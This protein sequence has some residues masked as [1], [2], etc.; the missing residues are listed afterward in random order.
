MVMNELIAVVDDEEDISEVIAINLKK[1]GYTPRTFSDG[2]AF[3][4]L[5]K[6]HSPALV[7]LDLMLPDMDGL[8]ICRQLKR[9]AAHAA[10]PVIMLTARGEE[11]DKL[12]G[13]ELGADDYMTKPFSPRELVARVKVVLRRN[14]IQDM[15]SAPKGPSGIHIDQE[16]FSVTINGKPVTLTTTE[17][18]ILQLLQSKPGCVFSR[19]KILDHVW[20]DEKIVIDRTVD[21]HIKNLR[22]KLGAAGA[23]IKNIRGIG[24]KLD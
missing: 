12:I 4:R 20:G 1:A 8:D 3:F 23:R 10:I 17:M 14:R 22:E 2:K 7:I 24:Y 11:T 13:L 5:L 19:E 15:P 6:T 16:R 21:V 18:K 9:D